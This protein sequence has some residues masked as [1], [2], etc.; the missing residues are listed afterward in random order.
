MKCTHTKNGF[1]LVELV[2]TIVVASILAAVFV[3]SRA[4][5]AEVKLPTQIKRLMG[6]IRYTQSLSMFR[7]TRYRINLSGST[8]YQIL[9]SAGT[10]ITYVANRSTSVPLESDSTLTVNNA[11]KY[12]VFDARGAPYLSA[13]ASGNG[14]ALASNLTV[15]IT[16]NGVTL[17]LVVTASTGEVH[18]S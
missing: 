15:S 12:L 5:N 1:T 18:Q 2:L 17:S 16:Q 8:S 6:D 11:H 3:V 4:P 10:P 9:N 14:T 7:N 13:T